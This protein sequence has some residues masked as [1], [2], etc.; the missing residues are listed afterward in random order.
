MPIK[1]FAYSRPLASSLLLIACQPPVSLFFLAYIALV[2][3]LLSLERDSETLGRNFVRG[4]LTGM[5]CYTGLVYWVVVA[6]DHYGGV[7]TPLSLL[8]LL[9]LVAYLALYIGFFTWAVAFLRHRLNLPFSLVAPPLWVLLEYTRG[10]LLSGFP[11]SLLAHSQFNFLPLL[12]IIS[13]TGTYYLSFLIVAANCV[14]CEWV[15]RR[16]FPRAYG[17]FVILLF[18]G[19]LM[20]GLARMRE[21]LKDTPLRASIIQGNIRQDLKFDEEYKNSTIKTYSSLTL[22]HAQGSDLIVW[23][24]T[25]MPFVFLTD[26][27]NAEIRRVPV[28]LSTPLLLGTISRDERQRYFNTAYVIGS[29]GEIVGGYSKVHLVPFGEYTPLA[30]YFPFLENISV[31]SGDFFSG[32]SHDPIVTSAGKVGVLI[33]YEGVFPY[34]TNEAVR[35]GSEVLVNMTNDAWFGPTSAP[36]QHFA[37][38]IF[39]AIETDRYVLRAA[40]T[41]ISAIIDPRGRTTE[42]TEIFKEGVLNGTY[43]LRRSMTI[44]VRY[45]DYFVLLALFLLLLAIGLGLFFSRN[46]LRQRPGSMPATERFAE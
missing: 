6:M 21:P 23:P 5:V 33:C 31:A 10:F 34:I 19:T 15:T 3:L 14:V 45:G 30:T 28:A 22:Q 8:A 27:A 1:K 26:P 32:P 39:R 17:T 4:F 20:F 11:W 41:G 12:Q 35:A 13:V 46:R 2:P 24:E 44:Y 7:G 43:S 38:Y 9:L 37:F 16:R 18:A 29:R 25:A 40:N 42:R 36:Y